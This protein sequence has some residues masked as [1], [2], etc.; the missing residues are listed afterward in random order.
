[1]S[2]A[3]RD[4]LIRKIEINSRATTLALKALI[5]A[6]PSDVRSDFATLANMIRKNLSAFTDDSFDEGNGS[7]NVDAQYRNELAK[8][9][10]DIV[11]RGID[12]AP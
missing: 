6:Q 2:D 11:S 5:Q 10:A 3:E 9:V 7:L 8:A 1:M 12:L 4:Q